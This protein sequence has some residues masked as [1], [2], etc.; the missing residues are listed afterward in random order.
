MHTW[1]ELAAP[2]A[3]AP[4]QSVVV[5]KYEDDDVRAGTLSIARQPTG[6][7]FVDRD[8]LPGNPIRDGRCLEELPGV[9]FL[10]SAQDYGYEYGAQ[11]AVA[12]FSP[13]MYLVA[14]NIRDT[15][16]LTL[17]P[18]VQ[19]SRNY[20]LC[21]SVYDE[22]VTGLTKAQV[23]ELLNG[24]DGGEGEGDDGAAE[25]EDSPTYSA[26]SVGPLCLARYVGA[27]NYHWTCLQK[28][29]FDG[30]TEGFACVTLEKVN[31]LVAL[32]PTKYDGQNA[33]DIVGEGEPSALDKVKDALAALTPLEIALIVGGIVLCLLC[34]LGFC[35][36]SKRKNGKLSKAQEEEARRKAEERRKE[37]E[38][39]YA[40]FAARA[41]DDDKKKAEDA[42]K[43]PV[44]VPAPRGPRNTG[45]RREA[46]AS[47]SRG[48]SVRSREEAARRGNRTVG[49]GTQSMEISRKPR[50]PDP[51]GQSVEM[52][53]MPRNKGG[54]GGSRG[55]G[56][57]S[58]AMAAASATSSYQPR[59]YIRE[60]SGSEESSGSSDDD[61][62]EQVAKIEFVNHSSG[63]KMFTVA[64]DAGAS[65][66]SAD[67]S[68][69]VVSL[70]TLRK[71]REG[72]GKDS[73][74]DRS[75]DGSKRSR[76]SKRDRARDAKRAERERRATNSRR[77]D[78]LVDQVD[79]SDSE[80]SRSEARRSRSVG[81]GSSG[82]K[83]NS[84]RPGGGRRNRDSVVMDASDVVVEGGD[85]DNEY[86]WDQVVVVEG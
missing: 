23:D 56:S 10:G 79:G 32:V 31:M 34:C 38:A 84:K 36:Y 4:A 50:G 39:A 26:S 7:P 49:I 13:V 17:P 69:P 68:L 16:A 65:E 76:D 12:Y 62:Q 29:I 66:S 48:I 14:T 18:P 41:T 72:S 63:R 61:V 28:F 67:D 71:E 81:K 5:N 82:S 54:A 20:T 58:M 30:S 22:G 75:K 85:G 53:R 33:D 74:R 51:T 60:S 44:P 40:A 59:R 8:D 77:L 46:S 37:E 3:P 6:N 42:M 47:P 86:D 70:A 52:Q 83:S 21:L 55:A 1:L 64:G 43:A 80:V 27:P 57:S 25:D 35:I 73:K 15:D 78:A 2:G 19:T 24:E 11:D 9:W 45:S